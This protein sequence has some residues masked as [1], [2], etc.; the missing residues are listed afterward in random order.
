MV[1]NTFVV[2]NNV[3]LFYKL[4]NKIAF[5]QD[6]ILYR[7]EYIEWGYLIHKVT[8]EFKIVRK[9]DVKQ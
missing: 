1:N 6:G 7:Q 8:A 3:W 2:I 9:K 5:L 4:S